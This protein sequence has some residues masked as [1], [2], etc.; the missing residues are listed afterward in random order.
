VSRHDAGGRTLVMG[1]AIG[2]EGGLALLAM[3]LGS[4]LHQPPL[5]TLS[6]DV[7]AA[8]IGLAATAPLVLMFFVLL[9]WPVGPIAPLRRFTLEV[10]CPMLAPCTVPDLA[11]I[12]L[13]AGFGEE[14]LFRGT[15][16]AVFT[17]SS[18]PWVGVATASLLFGILHAV[19]PAYAVLAALMGAYLGWLWLATGNILT[20]IVVHALYDFLVLWYLLAGPGRSLRE[21]GVSGE[22]LG[23]TTA[24]ESNPPAGEG[25]Q[26]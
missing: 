10:L 24:P 16:Q 9:R 25:K 6:F 4:L 15:L 22:Q 3:L 7:G 8:L 21:V 20:P 19:T 13:L 18:G 11:A 2:V 17:R 1:L 5:E 26:F 14:M 12:A 23:E